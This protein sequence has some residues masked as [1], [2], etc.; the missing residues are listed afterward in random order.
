MDDD[1]VVFSEA[2]DDARQML[3]DVL[4]ARIEALDSDS[5]L[6]LLEEIRRQMST[7]SAE[8]RFGEVRSLHDLALSLLLA[9]DQAK[10][11]V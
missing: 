4:Q 3:T 2:M 10:R 8:A 7:A 5:L 6:P 11:A 1:A 9:Q